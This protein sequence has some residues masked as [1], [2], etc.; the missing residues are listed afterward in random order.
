[1]PTF[2][3]L[4]RFDREFR[5]LPREMQRAFLTVLPLFIA[6]LRE[7]PPVFPPTLRVHRVQGSE[8]VWEITFASD[9]RA[10]FEYGPEVIAGDTHVIWRRIGGHEVLAA[11]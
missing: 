6:A 3:R 5:R 11:P 4:A 8:G 1:V 7:K 2:E 9:G 10:T